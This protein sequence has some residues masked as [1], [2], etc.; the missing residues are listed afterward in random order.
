MAGRPQLRIGAHGTIYRTYLGNGI[1]K[2]RCRYRDLDGVTRQVQRLGPPDEFDQYGKMA[3]DALFAAIAERRRLV[4]NEEVTP[5]SKVVDLIERHLTRLE[6]DGRSPVTMSTYRYT[7]TK[8]KKFIGGLRVSESTPARIDAAIRSMHKAHGATMARQSKSILSGAL[9]LAVMATALNTNPVR[10]VDSIRRKTKAKG[11]PAL[12]AQQVRSLLTKIQASEYCREADLVDPITILLATGLRRSEL[13]GLRW[14]DFDHE[15][16]TLTVSGKVVRVRGEGL[17]WI[18]EAKTESGHRTVALPRFA[19]AALLC[20]REQPFIGEQLYIFASTAGTL[21]D[22][23]NLGKQWRKVREDLGVPEVTSHSFRKTIA[24]LIDD[25]G[26]SARVGADQLGHSNVSMTQDR[27]MKRGTT[28]QEVAD[29]MDRA[30]GKT[31]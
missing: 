13:M 12:D 11:A 18:P 10:D 30:V 7:T 1:W 28:H 9:Q 4:S 16:A 5:D 25:E 27:Y 14:S 24:T 29:L 26:L 17:Q 20:R 22:A 19:V 8:L 6:E 2:A 3:E 23:S 31:D 21:R 15:K